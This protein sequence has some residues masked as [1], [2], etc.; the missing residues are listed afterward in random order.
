MVWDGT[1]SWE[2]YADY[3][4]LTLT[5]FDADNEK[6]ALLKISQY[7]SFIPSHY[8]MYVNRT[9]G[10][11]NLISVKL[12]LQDHVPTTSSNIVT[13]TD[14]RGI[15]Y[16]KS[17]TTNYGGTSQLSEKILTNLRIFVTTVGVGNTLAVTVIGRR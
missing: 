10:T 4:I 3:F 5:G 8:S 12:Q 11:T 7:L 16:I 13:I 15:A 6:T 2:I 17:S 9:T 14:S 1:A